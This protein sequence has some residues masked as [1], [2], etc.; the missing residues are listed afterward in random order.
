MVAILLFAFVFMIGLALLLARY[1]NNPR[2]TDAALHADRDRRPR[3]EASRLRGLTLDLLDGLGLS[4][5]EE[6][7]HGDSRR[8]IATRVPEAFQGSRYVVFVEALP[9]GD[10]VEQ[11]TLVELAEYVKSERAAVGMLVTPYEIDAGG[12]AGFEVPIELIDGPRFRQLIATYLPERL[13]EIDRFRGFGGAE[14]REPAPL[15]THPA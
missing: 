2:V 12:L 15:V 4:V 7:L 10:V 8:L 5:V 11:G 14:L 9:A 6:E 1:S 3:I 13:P